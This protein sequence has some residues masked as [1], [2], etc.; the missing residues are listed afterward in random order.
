MFYTPHLRGYFQ[1]KEER[2][3]PADVSIY[4]S[5]EE[6]QELQGTK[7]HYIVARGFQALIYLYLKILSYV[8]FSIII[9]IVVS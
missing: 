1:Y 5:A 6:L 3:N 8:V 4:N 7:L 2:A 9:I